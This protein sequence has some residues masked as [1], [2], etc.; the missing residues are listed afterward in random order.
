MC[1]L[2]H[3]RAELLAEARGQPEIVVELVLTLEAKVRDLEGRLSLNSANSS[4]PPSS[5]GL[6]K[7]APCSLRVKTGRKP[8]GQPGHPGRTLKQVETPDHTQVHCLENCTCGRCGG[9][10]L[11]DAPVVDYERR[12]VFDLPPMRLEVTEHRAEIK[13]CPI[14]GLNVRAAFPSSVEAP[15]QYG[16]QGIFI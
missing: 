15:V 12:Q 9:V 6:Q 2:S 11:K 16:P 7:P 8:G 4:K 10:S 3:R 1:E 14:S 5:D 13:R